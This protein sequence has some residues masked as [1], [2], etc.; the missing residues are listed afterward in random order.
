VKLH[1]RNPSRVAEVGIKD[2]IDGHHIAYVKNRVAIVM[3][4]SSKDQT[5]DRDLYAFR[6]F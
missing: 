5:L 4:W 2:F 6:T 1:R 3:E